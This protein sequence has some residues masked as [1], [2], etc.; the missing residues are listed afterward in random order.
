MLVKPITYEYSML[1]VLLAFSPILLSF[2]DVIVHYSVN[3]RHANLLV[4]GTK[5]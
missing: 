2:E 1:V 4:F 5:K 3:A